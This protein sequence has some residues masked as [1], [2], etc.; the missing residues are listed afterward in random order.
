M[1]DGQDPKSLPSLGCPDYEDTGELDYFPP[2]D[3]NRLDSNQD[4][5]M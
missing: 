5:I 1:C 2:L 4:D 3:M